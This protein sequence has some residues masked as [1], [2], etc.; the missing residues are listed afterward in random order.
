MSL[1]NQ[2]NALNREIALRQLK[3]ATGK[4][5]PRTEDGA[6]FFVLPNK[7]RNQ[8]RGKAMALDNIGDAKDELSLA[9]TGLIQIDD[10]LGNMRD[11]VVR[12]AN[13]T[14][15]SE[16]RDDIHRELMMLAMAIDEVAARTKFNEGAAGEMP[17]LDGS[18]GHTYQVGPNDEDKFH[19]EIGEFTSEALHVNLAENE[20]DPEAGINVLDNAGAKRSIALIDFAINTVKDQLDELGGLQTK[21]TSLQNILSTSMVA[22]ESVASRFGNAD[23]AR[24]QVELVKLQL[25]SQLATAQT[26]SAN[27]ASLRLLGA[28]MN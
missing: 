17:L 22:E 10:L 11:I 28:L 12:G 21:F 23:L 20:D 13:D 3:I 6:S 8:V 4:A 1:I 24:E 14:L 16:Q 27:A 7:M 2:A 18:F 26:A 19:V 5:Q 15:T 9:E 25:F